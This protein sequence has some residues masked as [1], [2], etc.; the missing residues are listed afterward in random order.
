MHHTQS[1]YVY[2]VVLSLRVT[3][4]AAKTRQLPA[5]ARILF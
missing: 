1:L 5:A 3:G 4:T 2:E